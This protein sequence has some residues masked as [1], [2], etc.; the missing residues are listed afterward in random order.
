MLG[1]VCER[2]MSV[3]DR[4]PQLRL[5]VLIGRAV[6]DVVVAVVLAG[7]LAV[8]LWLAVRVLIALSLTAF[9]AF[10]VSRA[11][12]FQLLGDHVACVGTVEPVVALTFDDGPVLADT[13]ETLLGQVKP[14]SIVLMH[15]MYDSRV[16]RRFPGSSRA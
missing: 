3:R 15:I 10:S 5:R 12:T 1:I 9:A 8:A 7:I 2:S 11:T 6:F 13:E 14:G 4:A 16:A